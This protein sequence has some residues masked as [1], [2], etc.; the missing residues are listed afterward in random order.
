MPIRQAYDQ[1]MSVRLEELREV[2]LILFPC[3]NWSKL[4]A[5]L[6]LL[7]KN[8]VHHFQVHLQTLTSRLKL[9]G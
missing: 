9:V 6:S 7:D 5:H 3:H 1:V 8:N 2:A 4:E